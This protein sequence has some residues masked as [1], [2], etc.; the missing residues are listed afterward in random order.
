MH[1]VP[2]KRWTISQESFERFL[3]LLD[4][5]RE[6]AGREYEALRIRLVRFFE[7]RS[8]GDAEGLADQV[9]DRVMRKLAE[10]V[11]VGSI[12]NYTFGVSKLVLLENL[13][14]RFR[15]EPIVL[16]LPKNEPEYSEDRR[17]SCLENCLTKISAE[18]RKL[19]LRYYSFDKQ[20]KMDERRRL[21]QS[22]GLTANALRIKALR[23]RSKLE[24]CVTRCLVDEA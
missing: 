21:A 4:H 15:E 5:D 13:K 19:I 7:W 10:G 11:E 6:R 18:S 2:A 12:A 9:L 23:V 17:L 24:D 20:A 16:D 22:L 3:S 14:M 8:C 1:I